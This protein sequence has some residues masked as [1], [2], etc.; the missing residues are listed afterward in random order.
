MNSDGSSDNNGGRDS[1]DNNI[2]NFQVNDQQQ[3]CR[4][5]AACPTRNR[6]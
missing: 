1:D 3:L 2:K 6:V 5:L 4:Q